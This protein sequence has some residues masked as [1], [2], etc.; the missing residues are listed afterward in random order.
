MRGIVI[1]G[2]GHAGTQAAI[3]LRDEGF[4]G[5]I[6]L[7]SQESD[8]PYHKPPLSKSFMANETV[9][10]QGLRSEASYAE[11]NITLRL[12]VDVTHIDRADQCL[13]L[14]GGQMLHYD[15]LIL[16]TG[17]VARRLTGDGANLRGVFYLRTAQD[18]RDMRAAL[19]G[20]QRVVVIGG[21]FIG[22]E[23]A[24]MLAVRGAAVTV[25]ELAPQILG[26]AVSHLVAENVAAYLSASGVQLLCG[27]GVDR[28]EGQQTIS[29]VHLADGTRL[30]ADMVVVGIG[31]APQVALA[32]AAGLDC[33]NGIV[34]DA[35]LATSDPAIFAIGDCAAFPQAQLG[36]MAR[37]E[38]VQNATDQ[39]RAVAR[40]LTGKPAPYTA[41]PWFWSDIG[42]LKL[43]IAGLSHDADDMVAVSRA[44]RSLQSVWRLAQ[45][46]LVAVETLD[47]AGEHMLARRLIAEGLTPPRAV[48]ASG[49]I[50]A[51][52]AYY[53]SA[54][55]NKPS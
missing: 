24:A 46:R 19:A 34:T 33:D 5:P 28:L 26:R 45:G 42:A 2:A 9:A 53:S 36:R 16:A 43:Q 37:L 54:A 12:G 31:A 40:T 48:M 7:I 41:L 47:S 32:Q 55:Q 6:T 15:N 52:K 30:A 4:S 17:T 35:A 20:A 22:L 18:A 8:L 3:S 10:L 21:G 13:H 1:L 27:M 51:L 11:K 39:A 44:D 50:G 29:A 38:S 14:A 23:A 49:D 25:V